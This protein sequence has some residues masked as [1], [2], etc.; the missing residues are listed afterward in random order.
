VLQARRNR[1][2]LGLL[3]RRARG[4]LV[5]DARVNVLSQPPL[6]LLVLRDAAGLVVGE[7]GVSIRTSCG[8]V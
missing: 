6:D 5:R 1:R 4:R 8:L 3:G 2:H 7:L